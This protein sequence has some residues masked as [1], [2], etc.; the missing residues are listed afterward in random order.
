MKRPS[1]LAVLL[2]LAALPA[3]ASSSQH[4]ENSQQH[5]FHFS[6]NSRK[7]TAPGKQ[8]RNAQHTQNVRPSPVDNIQANHGT[9]LSKSPVKHLSPS[10]NPPTGKL[11]LVSAEQV[12]A[13]GGTYWPASNGDFNGDGK[14]DAVTVVQNYVSSNWVYFISVVLGNGDGTFQSPVLSPIPGNDTCAAFVVGDVN[15]DGKDDILVVHLAGQCSNSTSN[16]D[17]LISNGDGTFTQGNN[18]QISSNGLSG[19]VLQ[20]VGNGHLDV[21]AVDSA[22]PSNLWTV[23]GNGDGTFSTSPTSVALSGQVTRAILTDVNADGVLDVV[24]NNNNVSNQVLV[25]VSTSATTYASGVALVTP[26]TVY[27]A[28]GLAAGDMTGDGKPEIVTPNCS[29]DT[30]TVYLN[31]GDGSF[32]TGAYFQVALD[33][34]P[35]TVD[36]YPEAATVADVNGDGKADI[37]SSNEETGD[38]T[39][40]LSNGDGTVGV[41]TVGYAT[42]GYPYQS[43][44]VA[45]FNGDGFADILVPDG[46]FSLAYLKG[47]GDGTFRAALDYYTPVTTN[48]YTESYG[49]ATGDFNGDGIP[50]VVIGNYSYNSSDSGITVFLSRPDGST[51]PGVQYGSGEYFFFVTVADFNKDGNLDIAAANEGS[52]V[53]QIFYGKGDGTFT[54]GP[55]LATDTASSAPYDLVA[56]DFNGDGYPDL[57]VVN[58]VGSTNSDVGILLNDG[59]GNFKPAV[60]YALSTW[61]W[62]GIAVGDL[63]GDGK[64][65]LAVPL[66]DGSSVAMLF[67]NG[68]GTFQEPET[69]VA[70]GA[71]YPQSVV[72]ADL[73]GDKIMDMAVALDNGGGEDVA[74][75]LGTGNGNFATPTLLASSLQNFNLNSPE[76]EFI[77]AADIDGDGNLDLVYTNYDYGTVGILFGQGNGSFYD[78]V[79]YPVAGYPWGIAIAD[80]N[81]DGAPDVITASDDFSG[82]TVALNAN[83]SGTMGNY[84]ISPLPAS[85]SVAPGSSAT[86]TLTITP[87]NH[88]NGTV[89]FA[90]SNLPALSK[91]SFNPS[92][93]TLNGDTAVTVSVTITTAAVSASL[94]TPRRTSTILLAGMGGMGLFGLVLAGSLKKRNPWL[95]VLIGMFILIM[96]FSL[97]GCG[98]VS[99]GGSGKAAPTT[100]A[101]NS[102]ASTIMVGGSV[103]FTA[104]VSSSSGTPTGSVTFLDGSTTLGTGTL[105]NGNNS[106]TTTKL[107]AGVHNITASYAGTSSFAAS[108]S[109]ALSETV[110]NPGTKVGTYTVTI[111]ATGTA[112]TNNGSTSPHSANVS[113]T[114]Q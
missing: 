36:T 43:A 81:N 47:Y 63:N 27:D 110:D 50:D 77:K 26:N 16:F 31:N 6:A 82:I 22:N 76:P 92:S 101:L 105:S 39:I 107:A 46:D 12:A 13:G 89:T 91:C 15:G 10:L 83:G 9:R 74:V 51:R 28:C 54:T 71:N 100:T 57:A 93:V 29:D 84:T 48:G 19:G 75:I 111:T 72:I 64:L 38:V 52:G 44:I 109:T 96:T 33:T 35:G 95:S 68:D 80:V 113:L 20:N 79:E 69:D 41:P 88:Y 114:V 4:N 103:T 5:Q 59:T 56:A 66:F 14:Q 102:S 99:T 7:T 97:V 108:T 87:I 70:L 40:L 90:C 60:P 2:L 53:V 49:V 11:G 18:Y 86:Y 55:T 106:F 30:V 62:Q 34:N 37:I 25:Y 61:A 23:L 73:N 112:G 104:N 85:A 1:S 24:G 94:E 45:D 42:G 98:G 8:T 21:V 58:Y 67:G 65:D 3:F 32:Q 78:P 17:V